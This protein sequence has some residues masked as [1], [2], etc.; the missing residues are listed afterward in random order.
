MSLF[1][2]IILF[3]IIGF[4]LALLELLSDENKKLY[5][6]RNTFSILYLEEQKKTT[7]A[8]IR[9]ARNYNKIFEINKFLDNYKTKNADCIRLKLEIKNIILERKMNYALQYIVQK[10]IKVFYYQNKYSMDKIKSQ[11]EG[12]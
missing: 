4:L 10:K 2:C 5:K 12:F 9:S 7:N 11:M 6:E 8:S 1:I 3:F